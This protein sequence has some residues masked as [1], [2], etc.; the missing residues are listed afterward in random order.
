M[1][2]YRGPILPVVPGRFL[3]ISVWFR[4]IIGLLWH[5]IAIFESKRFFF[6]YTDMF[7]FL[8]TALMARAVRLKYKVYE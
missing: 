7:S 1:D 2:M 4:G 8:C 6:R 5:S 3:K